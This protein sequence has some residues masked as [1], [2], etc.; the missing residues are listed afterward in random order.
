MFSALW[1]SFPSDLLS[2]VITSQTAS[3]LTNLKHSKHFAKAMLCIPKQVIH[4]LQRYRVVSK[5]LSEDE[6]RERLVGFRWKEREC[7]VCFWNL[8]RLR[9][10]GSCF[11]V[12]YCSKECQQADWTRHQN[13]CC[14][15]GNVT[16]GKRKRKR[17]WKWTDTR[18][19]LAWTCKLGN[20]TLDDLLMPYS[21]LWSQ[22]TEYKMRTNLKMRFSSSWGIFT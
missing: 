4:T 12:F 8:P 17:P 15:V 5:S 22:S 2:K 10:C 1:S 19:F 6:I 13:E 16:I 18:G 11:L 20:K 14:P 7:R 21:I 9:F 3:W